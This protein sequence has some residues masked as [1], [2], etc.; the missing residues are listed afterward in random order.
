MSACIFLREKGTANHQKKEKGGN[1]QKLDKR[2]LPE[3]T[4][5]KGNKKNE[6]RENG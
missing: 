2:K 3:Q 6:R 5:R 1:T 4:R